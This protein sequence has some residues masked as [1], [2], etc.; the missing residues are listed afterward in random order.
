MGGLAL[1]GAGLGGLCYWTTKEKLWLVGG[2][3]MA[4]LWPYTF[5]VLMPMNKELM[6]LDERVQEGHELTVDES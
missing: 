1:I 4:S 5:I 3:V 2:A 6:K